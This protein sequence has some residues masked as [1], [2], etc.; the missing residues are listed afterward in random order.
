MIYPKLRDQQDCAYP[1]RSDC[2]YDMSTE[3]STK[4]KYDRCK[5]MKYDNSQSPFSSTRWICTYKK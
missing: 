2:N 4:R 1:E 5:Y 3:D